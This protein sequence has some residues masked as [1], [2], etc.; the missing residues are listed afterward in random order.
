MIVLKWLRES[1]SKNIYHVR[2]DT[3]NKLGFYYLKKF[4]V[5]LEQG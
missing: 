1:R 5:P 3:L 4:D 2:D